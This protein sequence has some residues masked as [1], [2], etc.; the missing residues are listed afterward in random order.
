[1]VP[2]FACPLLPLALRS[3]FLHTAPQRS[4]GRRGRTAH[5]APSL[6]SSRAAPRP[7]TA[8]RCSNVRRARTARCF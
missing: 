3:L 5:Y 4:R 1:M 2:P 7:Q 8:Q 6:P